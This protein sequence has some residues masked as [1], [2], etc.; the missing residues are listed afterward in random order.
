MI[1]WEEVFRP[2]IADTVN[3]LLGI[4]PFLLP[5]ILA[6][7]G[8]KLWRLYIVQR[9]ISKMEWIMLEIK[10]PKEQY[11][12]PKAMEVVVNAFH[13]FSAISFIDYAWVGKV[14]PWSSLEIVSTEGKVRFMMRILKGARRGVENHIY[15]QYP[16]AEIHEVEDYVGKV[17]Y[18]E[19]DSFKARMGME[20]S[21]NWALFGSEYTLNKPD[22]YP[23][24]TYVD[25]GLD[26]E[27]VKEEYQVDPIT[28][29]L[30]AMGAIGK[31]EHMWFQI[32]VRA[33]ARGYS[34]LSTSAQAEQWKEEAK[35]LIANLM[36][37]DAPPEKQRLEMLSPGE[38]DVAAAV[39]RSIS[40]DGFDCGIRMIYVAEKGKF[41]G[42]NIGSIFNSL[43]Q[44]TTLNLNSFRPT[45]FT[46][47]I[48][49]QDWFGWELERKKRT[50]FKNYCQRNF[51]HYPHTPKTFVLNTEE[52][53][54]IYHFPGSVAQTP[55][56][57]RI[58]SKRAEAP[59]N[60]PI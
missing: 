5:F 4:L 20:P 17:H 40:K 48:D 9:F 15:S 57:G 26:K 7:L 22:A 30:E 24:K 50:I 58:E 46:S 53:A 2:A 18:L 8:W 56:F 29:T 10:I 31:G 34:T 54:T 39:E 12:S 33:A 6:F 45:R 14:W 28:P 43:K 21:S 52:L 13:Q 27:G 41:S 23:I 19:S 42:G 55:T 11:K 1:M 51:F 60:L 49:W 59:T 38:R 3:A 36:K 37:R 25:Y 44:Y 16:N 32:L 47:T 35:T